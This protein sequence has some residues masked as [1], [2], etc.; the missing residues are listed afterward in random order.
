[1]SILEAKNSSVSQN[2]VYT[3]EIDREN[4]KNRTQR[5]KWEPSHQQLCYHVKKCIFYSEDSKD[6]YIKDLKQRKKIFT[7]SL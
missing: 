4:S 3:D 5:R 1:M 7:L 2:I 6:S